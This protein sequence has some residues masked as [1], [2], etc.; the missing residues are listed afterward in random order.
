M[1][2][3]QEGDS[4]VFEWTLNLLHLMCWL[5]DVVEVEVNKKKEQ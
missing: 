3:V 4:N 5:L 1:K 2:K